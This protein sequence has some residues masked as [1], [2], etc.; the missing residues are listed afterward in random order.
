MKI[1]SHLFTTTMIELIKD[2]FMNF[3]KGAL[4]KYNTYL[5]MSIAIE[6]FKLKQYWNFQ[7]ILPERFH[8][9]RYFVNSIIYRVSRRLLYCVFIEVDFE[10]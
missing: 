4:D 8:F 10:K 1:F 6:N 7:L 2:K 5:L 9:M 3:V